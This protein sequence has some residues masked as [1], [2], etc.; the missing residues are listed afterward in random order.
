[1]SLKIKIP[2]IFSFFMVSAILITGY[3]VYRRVE[4]LVMEQTQKTGKYLIRL[5]SSVDKA[6]FVERD[7]MVM[8]TLLK[9]VSD[10]PDVISA[11][12][13]DEKGNIIL[14][15][16]KRDEKGITIREEIIAGGKRRGYCYVVLSPDFINRAKRIIIQPFIY[17]FLISSLLSV[18]AGIVTGV[19]ISLPIVHITKKVEQFGKGDYKSRIKK[20]RKGEMG[21]LAKTF[22]EMADNLERAYR[23]LEDKYREIHHLYKLA[24]EDSLSKLYIRRHFFERLN[25]ELKITRG[26]KLYIMMMDID[27]FKKINDTFGH[28]TGDRVIER[29][30]SII[31]EEVGNK[32]F[33]GRYGGEEFIS[34]FYNDMELP[35]RIRKRVENERILETRKVTISIGVTF[36]NKEV[37]INEVIKRADEALYKAKREGKNRV[38]WL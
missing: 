16:K 28:D 19:Y 13:E 36:F 3:F 6:A 15:E 1:M 12:F 26:K 5:L 38:V 30:A 8:A 32:G 24:T 11:G 37:S 4:F 29:I 33:S 21:I 10:Y 22:N 20:Y 35:E 31:K 2:L 18:I 27:D 14:E 17:I 25:F 7:Y 23:E 34:A 9:R